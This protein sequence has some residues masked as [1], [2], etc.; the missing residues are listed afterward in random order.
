LFYR[1]REQL[2]D[3]TYFKNGKNEIKVVLKSNTGEE[4][5]YKESFFHDSSLKL[6]K[7]ARGVTFDVF[8]WKRPKN[9]NNRYKVV[10]NGKEFTRTTEADIVVESIYVSNFLEGKNTLE[11]IAYTLSSNKRFTESLDFNYSF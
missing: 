4:E 11:V 5:C 6:K 9:S 7:V 2:L 10:F 3:T 1:K 8:Q